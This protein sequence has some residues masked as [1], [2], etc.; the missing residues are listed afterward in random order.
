MKRMFISAVVM[1]CACAAAVYA[2]PFEG[3][4]TYEIN[5]NG[6]DMDM[7]V[8]VKDQKSRVEMAGKEGHGIKMLMDWSSK[9]A[10]MLMDEQ[11]MAMSVPLAL[12][13][14]MA[15]KVDAREQIQPEKTGK[16]KTILG[17]EC[18]QWIIRNNDNTVEI[19]SAKGLGNF[20]GF[21][22]QAPMGIST[23]FPD[24]SAVVGMEEFFPMMV[25]V[26]N[27]AGRQTFSMQAKNVEPQQ[28]AD[29]MFDVPSSYRVVDAPQG[30]RI[31]G[32]R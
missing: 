29:S 24:V 28:L 27:K 9:K 25:T 16:T 4:A 3:K 23:G 11:Q 6:R 1:L 19:W 5:T 26:K 7:T 31:Q 18:E 22:G 12:P 30:Q 32:I 15:N 17:R 20:T 14:G 2:V 10:Y 8:Y 21:M 13:A